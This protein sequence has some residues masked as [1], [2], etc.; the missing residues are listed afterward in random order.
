[1]SERERGAEGE[2][3]ERG[4]GCRYHKTDEEKEEKNRVNSPTS[5]RILR[6]KGGGVSVGFLNRGSNRAPVSNLMISK[7]FQLR[8]SL[9]NTEPKLGSC[10]VNP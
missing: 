10:P 2:E 6:Y 8:K 5:S 4:V 1:V 3:R 9:R 7:S